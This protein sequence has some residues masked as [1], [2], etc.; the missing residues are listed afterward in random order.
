[1][2]SSESNIKMNA[3]QIINNILDNKNLEETCNHIIQYMIDAYNADPDGSY[4]EYFGN[5]ANFD[6]VNTIKNLYV[7]Q[8]IL[9]ALSNKKYETQYFNLKLL[10]EDLSHFSK[11]YIEEIL[12]QLENDKK[13]ILTDTKISLHS[14]EDKRRK[15]M[16][17][18]QNATEEELDKL[19]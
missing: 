17:K 9:N 5:D 6:P 11:Q 13:I 8:W 12:K 10:F 2:N 16:I 19:L 14:I 4:Y 1:M 15:I 3:Q 18:I 7:K